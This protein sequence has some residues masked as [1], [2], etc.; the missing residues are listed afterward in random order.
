MDETI[1]QEE[2]SHIVGFLVDC[3]L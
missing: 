3:K 2:H 1:L